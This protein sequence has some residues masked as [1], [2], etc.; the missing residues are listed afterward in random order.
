MG[1]F[2]M[3]FTEL[4]LV[5]TSELV[6]Q[7]AE[8]FFQGQNHVIGNIILGVLVF[9]LFCIFIIRPATRAGSDSVLSKGIEA[10]QKREPNIDG[11]KALGA[12][13]AHREATASPDEWVQ[14]HSR[15]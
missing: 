1:E 8:Y 11:D 4:W 10:Y 14:M 13:Y 6:K 3:N 15:K 2:F 7:V 9:N 12:W 5:G